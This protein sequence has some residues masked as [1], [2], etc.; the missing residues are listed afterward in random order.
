MVVNKRTNNPQ[1]PNT[2]VYITFAKR[3]D[4]ARAIDAVDG[5]VCEGRVIRATFGT[6]KY[7][8]YYLKSQPCQNVGCQFLHET[9]EEADTFGKDELI[10]RDRDRTTK[11]SV[12]P[13]KPE[14]EEPGLPPTASWAKSLASNKQ[15]PSLSQTDSVNGSEMEQEHLPEQSEKSVEKQ[16]EIV[17]RSSVTS[18]EVSKKS[19]TKP[20]FPDL[21]LISGPEANE[22]TP[23]DA[24]YHLMIRYN[25]IFDPFRDDL[26]IPNRTKP[27]ADA[28]TARV[29]AAGQGDRKSR[30]ERL[31]DDRY[32]E[33]VNGLM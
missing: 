16:P 11:P 4:A 13:S 23:F 20:A 1:N 17:D 29:V 33:K 28:I 31:F 10:H 22:L 32:D 2:G 26:T 19:E 8:S 21:P 12:F 27:K 15:F 24:G 7:C 25:G 9:G 3:E 14:K 5:S 6:T 30:F 18:N